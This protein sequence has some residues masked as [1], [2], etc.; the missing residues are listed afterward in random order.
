MSNPYP[1]QP[2][3]GFRVYRA[4][5]RIREYASTSGTRYLYTRAFDDCFENFDG[6]AVFPWRTAPQP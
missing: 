1:T 2:G 5:R 6:L 3:F 4:G